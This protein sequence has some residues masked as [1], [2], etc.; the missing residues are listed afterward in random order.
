MATLAQPF[1]D[2]RQRPDLLSGTPRAGFVDRWIF[3]FTAAWFVAIVLTGFIPDS[4]MKIAAVQTG[5]RPPFP[6][7][8]HLHALLMGSFLLLL[9]G[10][11]TL[12]ATG[13]CEYHRR[14]G[15]AA[16]A[17]APAIVLVGFILVPTMYH[18]IWYAAQAAP[19][20]AT[21]DKLQ[22]AVLIRGDIMLL[23]FRI[24]L[25]FPLFFLIGLRARGINAGLHKRM[26]ILAPAMALPAAID[27]I[28]WLPS[29]LPASPLATDLYTLL[30]VSPMF[31]WDVVRNRRVHEGYWIWFVVNLPFAIIV[32]GLWG[33]AWWHSIAPRLMGV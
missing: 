4:L 11:T 23:Q 33:S 24:G 29:T 26:M 5:E 21:R 15:I 10:Q 9:L 31:V 2:R 19:P 27:R 32:H 22:Q 3:V 6:V 8:L 12:M 7:V 18:Q 17:L 28:I 30:A 1:A 14:L 25:L 13:R 16:F 20:G